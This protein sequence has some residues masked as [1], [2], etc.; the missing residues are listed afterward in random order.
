[1]RGEGKEG[2]NNE[3]KK[4]GRGEKS[5]RIKDEKTQIASLNIIGRLV[6][7]EKKVRGNANKRA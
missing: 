6:I 4:I 3:S 1:M 5:H 2:I 7:L